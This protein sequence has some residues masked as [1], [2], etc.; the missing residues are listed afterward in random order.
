MN[1]TLLRDIA[2]KIAHEQFLLQWPVYA[3]MTAIA[4]VV[5]FAAAFV[6]AYAKKRG[7]SYATRAD[8]EG[9]LSQLKATTAVAEEVKARVSH[10]DW[11][12]RELRT[13]RR[14]KLEEL[15][16]TVHEVQAWQEAARRFRLSNG[17]EPGA[18]PLPKV[19]RVAGLYFPEFRENIYTFCQQSRAMSIAVL[20]A[21]GDMLAAGDDLAAR[22]GVQ[23]QH[24]AEV[25]MPRYQEQLQTVLAIEQQARK[26][27]ASLVN[28]G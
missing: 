14:L 1:E 2:E 25:W 4:L 21:R 20:Q 19:E 27:M 6:G 13:L 5:G 24:F 18:S 28:P 10:A 26:L 23:Q 11:A 16:Q 22:D 15:I 9:L 8:F 12:S 7:E 3:L 17:E